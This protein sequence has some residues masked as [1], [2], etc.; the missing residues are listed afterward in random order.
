MFTTTVKNKI[1]N[2]VFNSDSSALPT[3]YMIGLSTTT[4]AADGSNISEPDS[5]SG[6]TRLAINFSDADSSKVMN[7]STLEFPVFTA[8]AGVAT[9]YVIFDQDGQPY[10]FDL[11]ER[12]RT[13]E[14]ES[15]LAFPASSVVISLF[16]E[17]D[18]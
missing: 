15:V 9:H 10:W 17:S 14:A 12:S 11:L 7:S 6:Y 5:A 3:S 13:L 2:A 18:L 1:L 16:N 4:P 8:D